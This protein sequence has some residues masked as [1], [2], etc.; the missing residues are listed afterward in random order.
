[1]ELLQETSVYPSVC[2]RQVSRL[3][4]CRYKREA[5]GG[6][7]VYLSVCRGGD[8][9]ELGLQMSHN[10][11][12]KCLSDCGRYL[13]CGVEGD[14]QGVFAGKKVSTCLAAC[15]GAAGLGLRVSNNRKK[16]LSV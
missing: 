1:M 7:S 9:D 13:G 14:K 16:R 11:W 4:G 15:F 3:L 8:S 10:N 12:K 5:F 6:K 2:L